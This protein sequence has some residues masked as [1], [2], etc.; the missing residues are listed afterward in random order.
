MYKLFTIKRYVEQIIM[1]P[2]ILIG[3]LIALLYPLNSE[4]DIFFF[5]PGFS[6]GGA[7]RVNA[8]I[9]KVFSDKKVI[10]FFTKNSPNQGM[11]HFFETE[12]VTIREINHWT[13]NKW[14]YWG[15]LVYRGICSAY[16]NS[17]KKKTTVFVGQCNFGYKLTPHVNRNIIINELIHMF[18]PKFTWVWAPFIQFI[19][20]RVIVGEVFR[21][22]FEKCY[23]DSGIPEKYLERLKVI[24]YR[25]E[26]LPEKYFERKFELPLKI[27]Y[28]G[29]GGPQKRLWI[30]IDV[31]RKCRS[32]NLP[33]Q[34]KLAGPFKSE[35]PNDL[36]L[37]GTYVGEIKGGND[38]YDFHKSNDILLMTSAWEGFPLVIMEAMA[39]GT[40]PLVSEIDAIPE[41]IQHGVNGYLI[42]ETINETEMIHEICETIVSLIGNCD[43]LKS[44][45]KNAFKYALENFGEENFRTKYREIMHF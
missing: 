34:F 25:L 8:E 40:I 30:I 33:V 14:I 4:Y 42:R 41:H 12:N 37:D 22:K 44:N 31:I 9:I 28:A 10:I 13:D 20:I 5:F 16:I 27:Y 2:F 1:F 18:D 7:E 17:Q 21:S 36:I 39:F 24:F 6:I 38:M 45:S 35:L 19:N 11:K 29:R 32:K 26:Y 43:T 23:R 3:K 15:N